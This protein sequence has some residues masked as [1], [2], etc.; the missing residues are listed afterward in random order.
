MFKLS[1]TTGFKNIEEERARRKRAVKTK[2]N[3]RKRHRARDRKN[4]WKATHPKPENAM[5]VVKIVSEKRKRGK[6]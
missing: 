3:R 6:N 5:D 2:Q 1:D 4:E